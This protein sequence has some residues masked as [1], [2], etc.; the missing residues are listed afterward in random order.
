M[1]W[2]FSLYGFLKNQRYYEPFLVLAFLDKGL[3]FFVI[4]LLISF[5]E[6]ATNLMEVP[7]GAL[8]DLWG[9]RRSLILSFVA[10]AASFLSFGL[11]DSVGIL[12][13]AMGL[14]GLGEAFRTGTHKA[15]IFTWL[16]LTGREDERTRVYGFTRSWS[17]YGAALSVV[18][19]SLLVFGRG[20]YDD[21][22]FLSI[23]PC[24]LSI[25]NLLTYP[26]ELEGP[27]LD[28]I[29][30]RALS[31]HLWHAAKNSISRPELRRLYLDSMGFEGTFGAVKDYLQPIIK[32]GAAILFARWITGQDWN[33]AQQAA[34][35][36][37]PIYFGL[38]LLSGFASGQAHRLVVAA[39]NE[40]R[41]ARR[42]W[43]LA[44]VSYGALLIAGWF[45]LIAVIVVV[46]VALHV[47]QNLWRPILV[48]RFNACSD[49]DSGA[50]ILSIESQ[51]KRFSAA[52]IAP[53]LGLAVDA[54][55][56]TSAS[57]SFWPIGAI[58]LLVVLVFTALSRLS[59]GSGSR[60]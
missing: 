36:V 18:V 39:G 55:T 2:R 53:L 29:S 19:A 20:D 43:G 34:L 13:V 16:R 60:V 40:D 9:R 11:A 59:R 1:L 14:F 52:I 50:T 57:S 4:G 45:N 38:H 22:F 54:A 31:Q 17:K 41:A 21:I 6:I 42:L 44:V 15:M 10:Y 46:F 35:V 5:R 58:G 23:L 33:A 8:A 26:S 12:F 24:M 30:I 7:S 51:A 56:A 25:I 27:R 32:A 3:S 47:L 49:E 37:G 28:A 48:S